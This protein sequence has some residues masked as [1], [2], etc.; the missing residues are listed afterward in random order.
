MDVGS[1]AATADMENADMIS[2]RLGDRTRPRVPHRRRAREGFFHSPPPPPATRARSLCSVFD[3]PP[4]PHTGSTRGLP[5]ESTLPIFALM[6]T[7][8]VFFY[9]WRT[10]THPRRNKTYTKPKS[11][12][13]NHHPHIRPPLAVG[14]SPRRSG[15]TRAPMDDRSIA[16]SLDRSIDRSSLAPARRRDTPR[17][18]DAPVRPRVKHDTH[19]TSL[20]DVR[21]TN[22]R[23]DR[24]ERDA[25]DRLPRPSR[26]SGAR[27][28]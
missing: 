23:E 18:T 6:S 17:R 13:T 14:R 22:H 28:G 3:S 10:Y 24:A 26:G 7:C 19:S 11:R 20:E 2:V 1:A 15:R 5:L 27:R 16:R 8:V 12:P 9:V 25:R 21:A 4:N